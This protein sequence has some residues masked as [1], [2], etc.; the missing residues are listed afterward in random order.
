MQVKVYVTSQ[1]NLI[2]QILLYLSL[3]T[4]IAKYQNIYH[5]IIGNL[6]K[7]TTIIQI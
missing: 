5:Q 6:R 3:I 1:A 7:V 2:D 4:Q